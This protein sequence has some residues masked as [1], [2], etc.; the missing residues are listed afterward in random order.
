VAKNAEV[1]MPPMVSWSMVQQMEHAYQQSNAY[2]ELVV[3][4]KDYY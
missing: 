2:M 1:A 4:A 3:E